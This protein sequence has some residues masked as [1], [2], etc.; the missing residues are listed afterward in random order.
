MAKGEEKEARDKTTAEG[1][2][3]ERDS[4]DREAKAPTGKR[5]HLDFL[6]ICGFLKNCR[7]VSVNSLPSI[8]SD[9]W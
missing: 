2:R 6:H 4:N 5:P 3:K 1:K 7:M 8:A 9:M